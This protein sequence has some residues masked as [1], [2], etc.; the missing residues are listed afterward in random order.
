[1]KI[2]I[3]DIFNSNSSTIV[4]T[5]N[6]VGVMGKGIALE[7]KKKYPKMFSEYVDLCKQGAL[8]PGEPYFYKDLLG[9][10]ILVFPTKDHWRSPSKLSY[11][12]SGLDWFRNNY[13]KYGITSI[14]FP[15]LGCGNGGLTWDIVGP[16]MYSKLNDLP[17]DIE[18]YAPYG[19]DSS[20]LTDKYLMEH[21]YTNPN[22][23]IGN[24]HVKFDKN[25][26]LIIYTVQ[27]LNNDKYSLSVGRTI[28][29]KVCFV[30]TR[31]GVKTGFKFVEGSYGPYSKEIKDVITVL[32][33]AN[34]MTERR[35]GRMVE[36][37]V[38]PSFKLNF[39][40]Y[41]REDIENTERAIDLLS[42]IKSTEHA[43]MITTV[44]FAFDELKQK[45]H[46]V[47]DEDVIN[48]IVRW[49][50]HWEKEKIE[51]IKR[52][53]FNLSVLGWMNPSVKVLNV[54]DDELY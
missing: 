52:T 2:M 46:N 32:S 10:S 19:T 25:W 28:F 12:I 20:K 41:S 8:K 14:A 21:E 13:E 36:T 34:Y 23:I 39:E 35:L 1:M 4:N 43:E 30:L 9:T 50:P 53:I 51:S 16:V 47:T 27:Q 54:S 37:V 45:N 40:D 5:V 31:A 7:F 33:N 44:L 49:K 17:I 11:I 26:L 48:H 6:C 18:V 24:K 15:P 29:Q 42:R 22:D 3:G 38:S